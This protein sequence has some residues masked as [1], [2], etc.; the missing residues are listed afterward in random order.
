M[1]QEFNSSQ[2]IEAYLR[3]ELTPLER[4]S[5]EQRISQDPLLQNELT[6][7]SD[8]ISS[9]QNYRKLELKQRLNQIDVSSATN[10]SNY[11]RNTGLFAAL[12]TFLGIG[13]YVYLHQRESTEA[14]SSVAPPINMEAPAPAP[15]EQPAPSSIANLTDTAHQSSTETTFEPISSTSVTETRESSP[16]AKK[17]PSKSSVIKAEPTGSKAIRPENGKAELQRERMPA[18]DRV[19]SSDSFKEEIKPLEN[20]R[21]NSVVGK[22]PNGLNVTFDDSHYKF[23]YTS[24]GDHLELHGDFSRGYKRIKLNDQ[25]YL[26]YEDNFYL[27]KPNQMELAPLEKITD[28]KLLDQLRSNL[29]QD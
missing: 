26:Y 4:A 21:I 3:N 20:G 9:L 2:M 12:A 13:T 23:H 24:K 22:K 1:N 8:I 14:G 19:P 7:Q 18:P 25:L 15:Q 6:L 16:S 29:R 27:I 5:F 28:E 11:L 17:A 10:P